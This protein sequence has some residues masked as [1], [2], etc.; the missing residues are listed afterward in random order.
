MGLDATAKFPEEGHP[1]PWPPDIEMTPEVQ[2]LVTRRWAEY[3]IK[4]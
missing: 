3:G 2:A 4:L 1:R